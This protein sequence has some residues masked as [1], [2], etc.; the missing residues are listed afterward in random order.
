LR[1]FAGPRP[2]DALQRFTARIGRQPRVRPAWVFGPWFQ[3]GGPLDQQVAQLTKLR[4]ADAPVSVAQTYLH[5]LPCGGAR[6][7]EPQRT[8]ALHDL[9]VA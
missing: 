4:S 9:G 3:P 6:T 1:V 8:A 2:A 7:S 5:Y